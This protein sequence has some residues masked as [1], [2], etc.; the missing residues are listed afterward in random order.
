MTDNQDEWIPLRQAVGE[1]C[2][3]YAEAMHCQPSDAISTALSAVIRRMEIGV[4]KARA[5]RWMIK[6]EDGDNGPE[7]IRDQD[8]FDE[9]PNLFWAFLRTADTIIF[10]DWV[11]G[12]YS[13]RQDPDDECQ[14]MFAFAAGVQV[15]RDGLPIL[16]DGPRGSSLAPPVASLY[17]ETRGRK[18]KWDWEGALCSLI[19]KANTPDGLPQGPGSQAEIGK[20]LAAWFSHQSPDGSMPASSALGER[21]AKVARALTGHQK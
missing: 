9:L 15:Q 14:A 18:P 4:C 20:H 1:V 6:L 19:A 10:D 16:G 7:H 2:A 5:E 12:E 11:A 21:A 8:D 3:K 17:L 13:F